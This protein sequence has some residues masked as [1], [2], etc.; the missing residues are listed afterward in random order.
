MKKVLLAI[1][2]LFMFLASCEVNDEE[3]RVT[4][5]ISNNDSGFSVTYKNENGKL[6][7]ENVQ[8]ISSEDV[9][10]YQFTD[11]EGDIIY[12]SA[13]YKD[14]ESGITVEILLDGKVYKRESSLYDTIHFVT[15]SGT[16]P[17]K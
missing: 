12:I 7:K 9:W 10:Q 1:T 15:V 16:I 14:I 5:Q 3:R 2:V 13:I 11:L 4:Y 17:Y 8:V 6:V